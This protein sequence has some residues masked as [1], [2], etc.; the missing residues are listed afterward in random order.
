MAYISEA[1]HRELDILLRQF[2]EQQEQEGL[3]EQEKELLKRDRQALEEIFS[4]YQGHI[5]ELMELIRKY[6]EL[7]RKTRVQLRRLYLSTKQQA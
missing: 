6:N 4:Q 7:Y 3:H 5:D 1:K 2:L